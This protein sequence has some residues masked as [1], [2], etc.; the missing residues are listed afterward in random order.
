MLLRLCLW[1]WFSAT[2]GG[3][4]PT[5]S[6]GAEQSLGVLQSHGAVFGLADGW[7][8]WGVRR[9]GA[10]ERQQLILVADSRASQALRGAPGVVCAQGWSQAAVSCC[11]DAGAGHGTGTILRDRC[12]GRGEQEAV[13]LRS[14]Q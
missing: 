3:G 8:G 13:H 14:G 6:P 2:G 11:W 9:Q 5:P 10:V 1:R 12:L 4:R 7:R